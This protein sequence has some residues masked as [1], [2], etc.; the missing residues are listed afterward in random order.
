MYLREKYVQYSILHYGST[1]GCSCQCLCG[2]FCR[3]LAQVV[4]MRYVT[5]WAF[6]KRAFIKE[7]FT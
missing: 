1:N 5:S 3:G 7:N 4:A 2:N 6:Y